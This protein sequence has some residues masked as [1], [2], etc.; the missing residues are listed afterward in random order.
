[1][2]TVTTPDRMT[3]TEYLAME[4]ASEGKHVYWDGAICAMAGATIRHNILVTRLLVELGVALR[5]KPCQPFASDQRIHVP[6]SGRYFYPDA[7][8][9]CRPFQL[10]ADDALSIVNPKLLAEVL[11]PTTEAFDR[12]DKLISCRSLPSLTD[13]LLLSQHEPRVEHYEREARGAWRLV[14]VGPSDR[15]V[16]ASLEIDLAVSDLYAKLDELPD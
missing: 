14:T 8:V 7:S 6:G 12:G 3:V 13:Y 11:S 16:I 2:T 10:D 1:M 15:L 5:G 4:N 9:V